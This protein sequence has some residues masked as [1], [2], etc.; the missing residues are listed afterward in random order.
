MNFQM[1]SQEGHMNLFNVL[2][3]ESFLHWFT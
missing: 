2:Q 1:V 3:K